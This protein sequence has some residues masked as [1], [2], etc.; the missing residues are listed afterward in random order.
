ADHSPLPSFPTR[1]S[2][3]L[4][5]R[6]TSWPTSTGCPPIACSCRIF[7]C[8]WTGDDRLRRAESGLPW[9]WAPEPLVKGG[10]T[11]YVVLSTCTAPRSEEHTSA[12]QSRENL[13]C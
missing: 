11:M 7:G 2:S 10:A 8:C 12:L 1:R 3:D 4:G 9:T 13:V 6:L 5:S